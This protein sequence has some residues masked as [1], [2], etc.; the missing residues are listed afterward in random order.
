MSKAAESRIVGPMLAAPVP[1]DA[2]IAAFAEVLTR[3]L[4][5]AGS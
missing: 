5:R 4:A 2:V 1:F 3:P